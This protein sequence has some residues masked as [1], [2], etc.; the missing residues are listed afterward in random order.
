MVTVVNLKKVSR[1][2]VIVGGAAVVGA[3]SGLL[4]QVEG[5]YPD[6]PPPEQPPGEGIGGETEQL[7]EE[8]PEEPTEPDVEPADLAQ[9]T[10]SEYGYSVL[11]P[12]SWSVNETDPANVFFESDTDV[13]AQVTSVF[14]SPE[15][16]TPAAVVS[17]TLEYFEQNDFQVEVLGQQAVTLPDGT[18][19]EILDYDITIDGGTFRNKVAIAVVGMTVYSNQTMMYLETYTDEFDAIAIQIAGSLQPNTAPQAYGSPTQSYSI[20][21]AVVDRETIGRLSSRD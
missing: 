13:G 21:S 16:T 19:A 7:P 8:P 1:R 17:M 18:A 6:N 10:S 20:G 15:Q 3:S 11:Y 2:T 9:Y 4:T 12:G 5:Q 14:L